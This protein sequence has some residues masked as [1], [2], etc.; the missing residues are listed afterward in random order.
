[1]SQTGCEMK[2]R[3]G[4]QRYLGSDFEIRLEVTSGKWEKHDKS[5]IL[6]H[7]PL[8]NKYRGK[9]TEAASEWEQSNYYSL[10]ASFL[11]VGVWVASLSNVSGNQQSGNEQRQVINLLS[12]WPLLYTHN[13]TKH[14]KQQFNWTAGLKRLNKEN[15]VSLQ[16][17]A[18]MSEILLPQCGMRLQYGWYFILHYSYLCP[19]TADRQQCAS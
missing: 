11:S 18:L 8:N 5:N 7:S 3:K 13:K 17:T 9:P 1:M 6:S 2:Q 15:N 4:S 19:N 12:V 14:K 16:W 10:L